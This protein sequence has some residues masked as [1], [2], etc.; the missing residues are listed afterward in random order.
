M[1]E[2]VTS[3][4][5]SAEKVKNAME[6]LV[7]TGIPQEKIHVDEQMNQIKV[8]IPATTKPEIMEI[9]K[10]HNPTRVY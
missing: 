9:L 2:T 8:M 4:Y 5:D 1:T 3:I 10:R 7:G 6:D